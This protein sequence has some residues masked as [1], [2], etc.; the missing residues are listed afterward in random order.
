LLTLGVDTSNYTTSAAFCGGERVL[1]ERRPL[2]VKPGALGLRQ[3]D[4]LFHHTRQLPE[5]LEALFSRAGTGGPLAAVGVSDRPRNAEGSYMPCF[6]PGVCVAQSLAAALGI[7]LFKFS[8][9]QGHLAAALFSAGRAALLEGEFIAFHVSG[10]TTECLHVKPGL[11]AEILGGSGDLKA[12]QLVDRVG[13]MLGYPFP[14]GPA[15]DALAAEGSVIRGIQPSVDGMTCSFSGLETKL[16]QMYARGVGKA[17][18]ALYC[19]IS[20]AV[21]LEAL[22]QGALAR[23]GEL[24]ML[25][26]GGV[27]C[28]N[29]IR[30]LLGARFPEA[31]FAEP[32][33][34]GDNAAGIAMLAGVGMGMVLKAKS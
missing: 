15:V 24:P 20:V 12:G 17:D 2:P 32:E 18:V 26:T 23:C 25:F 6:L 5:L 3:S 21:N 22:A 7:P 19:L 8:H 28:S 16:R 14:A 34:S 30:G 11:E 13:V 33:F 29:I 4:A 9:Q 27:C 31:I 1:H 10:G